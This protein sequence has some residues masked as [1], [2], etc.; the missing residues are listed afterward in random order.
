[1]T[2]IMVELE[3]ATGLELITIPTRK[4]DSPNR[5]NSSSLSFLV[6]FPCSFPSNSCLPVVHAP[7]TI[8]FYSQ[9]RM[10]LQKKTNARIREITFDDYGEVKN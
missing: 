7:T 6:I 8:F 10:A 1:M 9:I 5:E 3:E 4:P 2:F